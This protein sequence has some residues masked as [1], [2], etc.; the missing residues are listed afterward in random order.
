M[1][2]D[3]GVASHATAALAFLI[4]TILLITGWKGRGAAIYLIA[5]SV[6]TGVWASVVAYEFWVRDSAGL[7]SR[8]LEVLRGSNWLFF[9]WSVLTLVAGSDQQKSFKHS[10]HAVLAAFCLTVLAVELLPAIDSSPVVFGG[11]LDLRLVGNLLIAVIGLA[12]VENLYRNTHQD[13][14]WGIKSLCLGV[15]AMFAYDLFLYSET[16]IFRDIASPMFQARGVTN[17]LVVP[18]IAV[19]A[20]RNP[21]WSVDVFVSRRAVLHSATFMGS[22]IYLLVMAAAVYYLREVGGNWGGLLQVAAL[23]GAIVLLVVVLF[24]GRVQS[25]LKVFLNKHFFSYNYDYR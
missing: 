7:A 24:S 22:G 15:G 16:L 13:Q 9:L 25:S 23:F 12:F 3:I 14:R 8:I 11:K 21:Q 17:A 18:L 4:L 19:S 6:T 5:A 1:S 10:S 20:A 2:I